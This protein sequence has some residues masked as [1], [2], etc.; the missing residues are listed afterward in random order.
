M[1]VR[2]NPPKAR[3]LSITIIIVAIAMGL[4]YYQGVSEYVVWLLLSSY[5]LL[6]LGSLYKGL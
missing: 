5:V 2:T 3:T 4:F 1:Q 6:M